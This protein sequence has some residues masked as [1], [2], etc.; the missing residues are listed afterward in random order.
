[1]AEVLGPLSREEHRNR[2]R[3]LAVPAGAAARFGAVAVLLLAFWAVFNWTQTVLRILRYYDPLPAWDY[4]RSVADLESYLRFDFRVLWHQ[5]NE[6][7]IAFPEIVFAAD[8]LLLH[9]RQFLPLAVSFLCYAGNWI[10]FAWAFWSISSLSRTMRAAAI[11]LAGVLI[12]WQGSA[13][14]LAEPFLL[15]WTLLEFAVSL[16]FAFL[17]RLKEAANHRYLIAVICC[18]EVATYSSGNG[19]LLWPIL[20]ALA[21]VLSID[22]RRIIILSIAAVVSIALYFVG[23]KFTG[24]LSIA[25]LLRHPLQAVGFVAAYMSMPFGAIKSVEFGLWVGGIALF[26]AALLAVLAVRRGVAGSRAGVVLFGSYLFIVATAVLTAA[27]RLELNDSTFSTAKPARYITEPLIAWGALILL[28]LWLCA[29]SGRSA[30][31]LA[32]A[33][34]TALLLLLAFPKFRWWLRGIDVDRANQQMAALSIQLGIEDPSLIL[35]IFPDPAGIRFWLPRLRQHQVSTFYRSRAKWLGQDMQKFA[36]ALDAPIPGEIT[37]RF[38]VVNG[39][40]VSGWFDDSQVRG[41]TGWVVLV[42]EER[43]IAGFGRRLPAGF[44]AP[45]S[46]LKTPPSLGWV[47]FIN[48]NYSAKQIAAYVINKRGLLPLEGSVS[49]PDLQAI[50]RKKA[51]PTVQGIQWRMDSNWTLRGVPTESPY[52]PAPSGYYGSWSGSDAKTGSIVSSVFST[53]ANACIV[54]PVLQG[55]RD[56]GLSVKVTDADTGR[57]L[58]VVP[59]QNGNKNWSYWRI[60]VDSSTSR[61]KI[62]AEDHGK[63]WGEWLAI[64]SPHLCL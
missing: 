38:P 54:L 23:Y 32:I 53:P 52:D 44:P 31:R 15:Q 1:M 10:V 26:V 58:M 60:P 2:L 35:N 12:G 21:V 19:M 8:Y 56:G 14:V 59:F 29:P 28:G 4:W 51:G 16:S 22:K 25:T 43:K 39:L 49:V 30:R 62:M 40:E 7:R 34:V 27:G 50:E 46:N 11:L 18:A 13:A 24:T 20:I 48:L 3:F 61:L 41:G 64:A 5:H 6:H 63:D 33:G 57:I 42:N 55:P 9:G 36:A 45:A 17:V 37:Y 47:G